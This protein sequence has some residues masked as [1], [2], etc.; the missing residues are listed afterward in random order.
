MTGRESGRSGKKSKDASDDD[1]ARLVDEIAEHMR[2]GEEVNWRDCISQHPRHAAAL[3]ELAPAIE[4]L[5]KF[6]VANR[7]PPSG[8][9]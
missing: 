6:G 5:A 3:R 9:P 8:S 4:M 7:E 1:L 2:Q